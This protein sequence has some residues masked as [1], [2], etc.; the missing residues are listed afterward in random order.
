LLDGDKVQAVRRLSP[1]FAFNDVLEF[2]EYPLVTVQLA[3]VDTL[4]NLLHRFV[5]P[6]IGVARGNMEK[7]LPVYELIHD[8]HIVGQDIASVGHSRWD[9]R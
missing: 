9:F 1:Q 8:I 5:G 6:T 4:Y 3:L 7:G 2:M